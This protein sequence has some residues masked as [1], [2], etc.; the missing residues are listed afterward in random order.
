[1]S[2][3]NGH[4]SIRTGRMRYDLEHWH[5]DVFKARPRWP[6]EM[7]SRNFFV[8]FQLNPRGQI[9]SFHFSTGYEFRRLSDS[10]G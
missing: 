1:M 9:E 4:L 3:E 5:H 7:E 8:E 10:A 2:V 6:Y